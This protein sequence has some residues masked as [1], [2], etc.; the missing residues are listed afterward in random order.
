[1]L[2]LKKWLKDETGQGI[3]EYGLIVGL[4]AMVVITAL[5]I[6][7]PKV[8]AVFNDLVENLSDAISDDADD[9]NHYGY[10]H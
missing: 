1:M 3:V 2:K 9:G 10:G 4:I 8:S 7:S 5:L 6:L